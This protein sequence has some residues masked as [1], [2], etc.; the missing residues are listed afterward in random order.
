MSGS[1]CGLP[2]K[3]PVQFVF[4]HPEAGVGASNE[5]GWRALAEYLRVLREARWA[6]MPAE[7]TAEEAWPYFLKAVAAALAEGRAMRGVALKER[8]LLPLHEPAHPTPSR[9]R[10]GPGEAVSLSLG[11]GT[12]IA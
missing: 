12:V 7:T 5:E 4:P 11:S 8:S 10:D 6:S 9:N 2:S 1:A 3:P